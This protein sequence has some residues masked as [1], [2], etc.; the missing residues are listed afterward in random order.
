MA[1]PRKPRPGIQT[2]GFWTQSD[3]SR[4]AHLPYCLSGGVTAAKEGGCE[5][6]GGREEVPASG[7][8]LNPH[9]LQG[10]GVVV[11]HLCLTTPSSGADGSSKATE[12]WKEEARKVGVWDPGQSSRDSGEGLQANSLQILPGACGST[13][14]P[15][16][17]PST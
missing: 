13:V 12:L 4:L 16:L 7:G 5:S 9:R 11:R 6:L 15:L 1:C 2:Q 8:I 17:S 3:L 14:I 10:V